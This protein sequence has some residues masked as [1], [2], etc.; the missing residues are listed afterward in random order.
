MRASSLHTMEQTAILLGWS[1]H[2]VRAYATIAGIVPA[3][4]GHYRGRTL[5]S[6]A[7]IELLRRT[8]A[9]RDPQY[10]AVKTADTSD[11]A[12]RVAELERIVEEH[13]ARL[14]SILTSR[15]ELPAYAPLRRLTAS[16]VSH[17]R[18]PARPPVPSHLMSLPTWA[19]RHN[20]KLSTLKTWRERGQLPVERGQWLEEGVRIDTALTI[21]GRQLAHQLAGIPWP[22]EICA[23]VEE[24]ET[25]HTGEVQGVR[26]QAD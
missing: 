2:T 20:A 18:I 1:T 19:K 6:D 16:T 3:S 11:L 5:Y 4:S 9:E 24:N 13:Q 7:D 25:P 8:R 23:A 26:S 10:L 22:C 14:D 12:A 15:V 21:E 17:T